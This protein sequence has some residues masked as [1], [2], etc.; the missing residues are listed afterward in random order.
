MMIFGGENDDVLWWCG[1]G[2]GKELVLAHERSCNTHTHRLAG[3]ML[4]GQEQKK[5]MKERMK[6]KARTKDRQKYRLDVLASLF[7]T[8]FRSL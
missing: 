6:E 2:V 5:R 3:A 1:D 4:N 8:Q 7:L